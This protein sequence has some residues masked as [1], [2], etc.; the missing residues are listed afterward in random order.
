MNT[1]KPYVQIKVWLQ[2][3]DWQPVHRPCNFVRNAVICGRNEGKSGLVKTNRQKQLPTLPR[4]SNLSL[5]LGP[6]FLTGLMPGKCK[7][8]FQ[9]HLRIIQSQFNYS[10]NIP[11]RLINAV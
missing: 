5:N 8:T 9:K 2:I 1:L 10:N 6:I 7:K 4:P 3:R 11:S